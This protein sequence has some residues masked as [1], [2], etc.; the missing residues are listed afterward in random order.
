MNYT[1]QNLRDRFRD[2]GTVRYTD[3]KGRGTAVVRFNSE[4]DA[5]RAVDMMNGIRIENRQIEV[6]LY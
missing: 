2:V 6:R 5:Q 3:V 1:W 4:R